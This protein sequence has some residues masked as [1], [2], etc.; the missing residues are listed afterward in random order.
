MMRKKYERLQSK[1]VKE[2]EKNVRICEC[3]WIKEYE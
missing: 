2:N 3:D 1:K